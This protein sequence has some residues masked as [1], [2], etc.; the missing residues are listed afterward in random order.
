M[1]S[2]VLKAV[3]IKMMVFLDMTYSPWLSYTRSTK[4]YTL[5][6][7]NLTRKKANSNVF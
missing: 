6:Q 7:I 4:R 2:G 5:H 1:R 3:R